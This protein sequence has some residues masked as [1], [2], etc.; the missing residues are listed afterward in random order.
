[1]NKIQITSVEAP[2]TTP[3]LVRRGV[4][5]LSTAGAMGLLGDLEISTLNADALRKVVDM[6]AQAGIGQEA[7]AELSA[8]GPVDYGELLERLDE[9]LEESAV[10]AQEWEALGE[11]LDVEDLASLLRIASASVRRYRAG[12]RRT[13]DDVAARL[14]FLASVVGDLAGAYNG[15]GIRRWFRRPRANL[16]GKAP[17]ELLTDGWD[18]VDPGARRV[19]ELAR[20]L[21]GAGA[22]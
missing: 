12:E 13:P 11:L 8:Q 1:M 7:R 6:L 19:R 20:G 22:T 5:I 10:P 4:R 14:H 15:Y 16:D 9:A 18:P 3:Q 21:T 17:A 2:F